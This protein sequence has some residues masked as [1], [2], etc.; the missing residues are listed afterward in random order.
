MAIF[1]TDV[2]ADGMGSG[3]FGGHSGHGNSGAQRGTSSTHRTEPDTNNLRELLTFKTELALTDAQVAAIKDIRENTIKESAATM[4][5]M[6]PLQKS[7]VVS[8]NQSRPD[9]PGARQH[10][11]EI[12]EILAHAQ[13]I[14]VNAYE[15]AYNLLTEPQKDKLT[16]LKTKLKEEQE[17]ANTAAQDSQPG[18]PAAP[19]TSDAPHE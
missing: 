2:R 19:A 8:L 7:L 18:Q 16:Y 9:F 10:I 15:K 3:S 4:D 12:A 11:K 17:K 13:L 6:Q 14:S 1:V 5:A